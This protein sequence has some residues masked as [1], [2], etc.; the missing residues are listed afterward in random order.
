[1]FKALRCKNK[2]LKDYFKNTAY[3]YGLCPARLS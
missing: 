3:V 1:M 2:E